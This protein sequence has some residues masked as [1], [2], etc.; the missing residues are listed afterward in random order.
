MTGRRRDPRYRLSVPWE[1]SLLVLQDVVIEHRRGREVWAL[2]ES[3]AIAGDELTMD[4]AVAGAPE[5]RQLRVLESTPVISGEEVRYRLR[6]AVK[7]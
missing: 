6:L 4:L 1:G 2:S 5:V 3:P 7:D